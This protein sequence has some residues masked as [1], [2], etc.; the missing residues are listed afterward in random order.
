MFSA[1]KLPVLAAQFMPTHPSLNCGLLVVD[2]SPVKPLAQAALLDSHRIER[3]TD[4]PK[5]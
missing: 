5:S 2:L 1:E 4:N 3:N